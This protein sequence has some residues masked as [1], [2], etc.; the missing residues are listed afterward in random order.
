MSTAGQRRGQGGPPASR[1]F[2]RSWAEDALVFNSATGTPLTL[3]DSLRTVYGLIQTVQTKVIDISQQVTAL[4][5]RLSSSN[6]NDVA[7]AMQ[8]ITSR[9]AA[10]QAQISELALAVSGLQQ[11]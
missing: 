2:Q 11:G 10:Q 3:T 4:Q 7:L 5:A 8:D 6:Q 1:P 9:L